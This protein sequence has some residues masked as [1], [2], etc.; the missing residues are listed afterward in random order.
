MKLSFPICLSV[1]FAFLVL[2]SCGPQT[3]REAPDEDTTSVE[4][5]VTVNPEETESMASV[6]ETEDLLLQAMMNSRMYSALGEIASE[7]ASSQEVKDFASE[8]SNSSEEIVAKID[9]LYEAVGG[10]VPQALGVEQ[11]AKL[12]S[13]QKFSSAEFDQV[14]V[15]LVVQAHQDDIESMQ[16][17]ET[18]SENPVMIGLAAEAEEL[19]QTQLEQAQAIQEESI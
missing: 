16:A 17:L 14:F 19:M 7:K 18:E 15:N 3:N 5:T 11:Q 1:L 4:D 2:W 9:Q 10:D 6:A 8:L 13:L 12:D